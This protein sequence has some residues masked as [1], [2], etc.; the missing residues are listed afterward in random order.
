MYSLGFSSKNGTTRRNSCAVS[1]KPPHQMRHPGD[2]ASVN[3]NFQLRIFHR[4]AGVHETDEIGHH[5]ER[6][7]QHL[8]C[9]LVLDWS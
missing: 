2:T 6:M 9:I 4:H 7:R 5:R 3:T 1:I 8:P